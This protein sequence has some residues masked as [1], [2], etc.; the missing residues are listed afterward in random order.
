MNCQEYRNIELSVVKAFQDTIPASVTITDE[1]FGDHMTTPTV[2]VYMLNVSYRAF[3]LGNSTDNDVFNFAAAVFANSRQERDYLTIYLYS[4]LKE[5][6]VDLLDFGQNPVVSIGS[7][8]ITKPF[9]EPVR[10][11]EVSTDKLLYNSLITFELT[12]S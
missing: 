6:T 10:G 12:Y 4:K 9:A 7:L 5:W 11:A 2:G 3:E 8:E 1:E